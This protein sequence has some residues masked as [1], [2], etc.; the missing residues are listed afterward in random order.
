MVDANNNLYREF[1]DVIE[2][3]ID[4][5][6]FK[7]LSEC[8]HHYGVTR[9]QHCINVAYYSFVVCRRL[10]LN[11]RA[12][13][14]AGL[15]HDLFYYDWNSETMSFKQHA[16]SHSKDALKNAEKLTELTELE[17]D[18]IKNHMWLCGAIWPRYRETY[19]VSV[20]DKICALWE[21]CRGVRVKAADLVS[22]NII[23]SR[24]A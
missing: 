9:M 16:Y 21:A 3:L 17:R 1:L 23:G 12:A 11:Y 14:R 20:A 8:R 24:A 2:N 22:K 10:G 6:E 7:R 4:A 19:I 15:L 13:A 18:I 5:P